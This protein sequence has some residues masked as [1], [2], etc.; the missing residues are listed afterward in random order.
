MIS[1]SFV[2]HFGGRVGDALSL[3]TPE[4]PIS[5]RVVAVVNDFS[6]PEGLVYLRRDTY[7]RYWHDP[8]VTAFAVQAAPGFTPESVRDAIAGTLGD[9][10]GLVPTLNSELRE[11]M[12]AT[13]RESF[14]YAHAI[15]IAALLVGLLG[16]LSTVVAS[17][18]ERT[19]EL[20]MLRAVGMSRGQLA[21]MILFEAALLGTLGGAVAALLGAYVSYTWVIGRLSELVGWAIHV[22]IAWPSLVATLA[23]GLVVGAL[24]GLAGSR[25]AGRLEIR[26]AL[27]DE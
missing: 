24:A 17:V 13:I 7:K 27:L 2:L 23:A 1:E 18:L 25:K 9:T 14:A 11:Q 21:R 8:L 22:Q 3:A 16:L 4:G 26:E 10:R 20:G 5:L 6:S 12:T 19:R 15:E